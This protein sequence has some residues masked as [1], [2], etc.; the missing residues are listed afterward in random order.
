MFR[1]G[2]KIDSL[3]YNVR[4]LQGEHT[5]ALH[6]LRAGPPGPGTRLHGQALRQGKDPAALNRDNKRLAELFCGPAS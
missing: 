2:L 6:L 1:S 3:M 5:A 4:F